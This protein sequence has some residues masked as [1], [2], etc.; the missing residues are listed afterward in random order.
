[1]KIKQ[2]ISDFIAICFSAGMIVGSAITA[3]A[4]ER[5]LLYV[6]SGTTLSEYH[7]GS[8]SNET[9]T[10]SKDG[11]TVLSNAKAGDK[12]TITYTLTSTQK[13]IKMAKRF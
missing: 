13:R 7:Y 11:K 12:L 1:M 3:N 2:M 8:T 10:L 5:E 9:Y 6:N 4:A